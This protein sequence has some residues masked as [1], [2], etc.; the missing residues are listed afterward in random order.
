MIGI[1]DISYGT[2]DEPVTQKNNLN[3]LVNT[4]F[5][6]KP[7]VHL[8]V[9]Q[10]TPLSIYSG[11]LVQYNDY[12]RDTL[13]PYYAGQGYSISTV[14]Q[15]SNFLNGVGDIDGTLFSNGINHPNQTGYQR[16][17]QTWFTGMIQL[18]DPKCNVMDQNDDCQ[19]DL[20]DLAIFAQCWLIDCSV[21]IDNSC[22]D[23]R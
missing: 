6:T 17:A 15:Y 10:I 8:I 5:T 3:D 1:N 2:N 11:T 22:C 13:V 7:E 23:W 14:D 9:A 16:M 21:D 4:I 12:I 18:V 20:Y 19:F